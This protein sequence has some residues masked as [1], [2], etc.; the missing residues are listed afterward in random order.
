MIPAPAEVF[1]IDPPLGSWATIWRSS[2]FMHRKTA[3]RLMAMSG[4]TSSTETSTNGPPVPDVPALLWAQSSRP[5][6]STAVRI[7]RSTS[8][9]S[10]TSARA[11]TARRRRPW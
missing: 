1:T 3:V 2:C 5:H 9:S 8:D 7:I 6:V 10:V 11:G 4:S